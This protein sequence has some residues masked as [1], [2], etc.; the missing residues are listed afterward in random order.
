MMQFGVVGVGPEWER[1]RPSLNKLRRPARIAAVY[2][3]V[4]VR[5]EQIAKNCEAAHVTGL[6]ALSRR[7]DVDFILLMDSG[8]RSTTALK[9]FAR[10]PKPVLIACWLP[11]CCDVY[12]QLHEDA[13]HAGVPFM[14]TMWRRFSPA[15]MRIQ[16][17][18]AI[19]LGPPQRI[20]IDLRGR[21][22][23]RT[24]PRLVGWLDYCRNFFK[25]YPQ[26]AELVT[27]TDDAGQSVTALRIERPK[28]VLR[29]APEG[30][31]SG[32]TETLLLLS[33]HEPERV[34]ELLRDRLQT[35]QAGH[36]LSMQ[37]DEVAPRITLDCEHG[38]AVLTSRFDLQWEV[39]DQTAVSEHLVPDRSEEEIMMDL[40]CRRAV[41]GLIPV[42][43]YKDIANAVRM[44]EAAVR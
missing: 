31:P 18:F 26:A 33:D 37:P 38:R 7:S 6:Q 21:L 30:E 36:A 43:D 41:G 11:A 15:S 44:I 27:V 25:V 28:R 14:P 3:S 35:S 4:P 13:S 29:S 40:F 19:E 2:D 42:A 24:M 17:L 16:E 34:A 12:E 8:W 32:T 9:L 5:A 1:F 20:T 10:H 23:E 22:D 39:R